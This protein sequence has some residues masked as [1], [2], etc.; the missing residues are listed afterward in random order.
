MTAESGCVTT[1]RRC[2]LERMSKE[3]IA[4]VSSQPAVQPRL[5]NWL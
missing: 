5:Y 4:C 3:L 1:S 2:T